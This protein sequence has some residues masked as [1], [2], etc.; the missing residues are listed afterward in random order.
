F[1]GFPIAAFYLLLPAA[2]ALA[3]WAASGERR[4]RLLA[5]LAWLNLALQLLV[6]LPPTWRAP[7]GPWTLDRKVEELRQAPLLQPIGPD[8]RAALI[9]SSA[10]R[11]TRGRSIELGF[12]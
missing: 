8:G 5:A 9:G 2:S 4:P 11:V 10:D 6:L 7:I 12:L 3:A 1:K